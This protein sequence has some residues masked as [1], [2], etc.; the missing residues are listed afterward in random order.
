M[1]RARIMASFPFPQ[2]PRKQMGIDRQISERAYRQFYKESLE[3][4]DEEE[5]S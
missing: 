4:I 5:N 2:N 1:E 3:F